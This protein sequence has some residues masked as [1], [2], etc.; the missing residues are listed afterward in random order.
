MKL[1]RRN[2]LHLA[3][4]A[5]ALPAVS[6][7][8][9]AQA[10]PTRPVRI[11]I[12]LISMPQRRR[13]GV[14]APCGQ[15]IILSRPEL[16][17]SVSP[18]ANA[19]RPSSSAVATTRADHHPPGSGRAGQHRRWGQARQRWGQARQQCQEARR[20]GQPRRSWPER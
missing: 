13:A 9:W 19:F 1:P 3:A 6:R 16:A 2:F 5:A 17:C 15:K 18:L 12:I 14:I 4:G 7:F 20:L 11:E 10:Y 8:A